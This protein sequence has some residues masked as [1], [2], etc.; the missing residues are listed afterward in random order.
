M[1]FITQITVGPCSSSP[2]A[3]DN[4]EFGVPTKAGPGIFRS[5][6]FGLSPV[7]LGCKLTPVCLDPAEFDIPKSQNANQPHARHVRDPIFAGYPMLNPKPHALD[8][9]AF[10]VSKYEG[11]N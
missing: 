8:P 9:G 10:G 5:L 7:D 6:T 4:V 2:H 11:I 1:Y 3:V